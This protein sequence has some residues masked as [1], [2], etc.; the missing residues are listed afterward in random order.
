MENMNVISKTLKEL[1]KNFIL[2]LT[3]NAFIAVVIFAFSKLV[4]GFVNSIYQNK[5]HFPN[6]SIFMQP[7]LY[8]VW[9]CPRV[10]GVSHVSPPACSL[11][12]LP[13]V[14]AHPGLIPGHN[15]THGF[16][17]TSC[18]THT[19]CSIVPFLFFPVI[20]SSSCLLHLLSI[21]LPTSA[22]SLL[23]FLLFVLPG[24]RVEGGAVLLGP[25]VQV[26]ALLLPPHHPP[27]L[28]LL[29]H[30]GKGHV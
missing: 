10:R 19:P 16:P 14:A 20:S 26:V 6:T 21:P 24:L 27:H 4:K 13:A 5:T 12:L 3:K 22:P 1:C 7:K 15:S 30:A 2:K 8:E 11:S 17:T 23:T 9:W 28:H 29:A 18:H 25:G